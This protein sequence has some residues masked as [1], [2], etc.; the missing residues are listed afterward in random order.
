MTPV[1]RKLTI[2]A[3]VTFSVGWLGA[4]AGFLA[5]SIVGLT[6]R[7]AEVVRGAYLSMDLISKFVIIPMCFAA[8]ATGLLQAL[9]TPWGLFRYYWIVMKFSLAIFATI[10]LLIHQ[11]AVM[12]VAAKRVSGGAT[13]TLFSADLGPLKTELVRAPSI[14]VVLLLVATTLGVY[15]PWGLTRYGRR[16]QQERR[17]VQQQ[18]DN[19]TPLGVKIFFAVS[20]AF[21]LVFVV[22]H[23][24]GHGFESHGH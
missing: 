13:E 23:L 14:A 21:V 7:D 24:T 9:G 16:K 19:E 10:A 11:F 6:S 20:G 15:K 1:L 22:L 8:L 4:V 18:P 3:H 17:K 2:T 12:A 5:L